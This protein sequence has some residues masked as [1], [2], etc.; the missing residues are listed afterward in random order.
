MR[1]ARPTGRDFDYGR[2]LLRYQVP[3][4]PILYGHGGTHFGVS[5]LAL[6]ADNARTLI[7]YRNSWDRAAGGLRLDNPLTRAVFSVR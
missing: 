1:R 5:C 3:D 4:G 7:L 2:G 6:R